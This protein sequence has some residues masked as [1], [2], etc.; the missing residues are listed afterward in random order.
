MRTA[1][2]WAG[3]MLG[4]IAGAWAGWYGAIAGLVLGFMVDEARSESKTR[5]S[6]RAFLAEPDRVEPEEPLPG[7]ASAAALALSPAFFGLGDNASAARQGFESLCFTML[8]LERSE[9]RWLR[10]VLDLT[11]RSPATALAQH[12]R[13]LA[14]NGCPA[15]R[16]LL[17]DFCYSRFALSARRHEGA[18][19]MRLRSALADCG[20]DARSIEESRSSAFPAARDPWRIL[21]LRPGSPAAEIRRAF[22]RLSRQ[23]HPDAAAGSLGAEEAGSRFMA[24]RSAYEELMGRPGRTDGGA[25]S[26]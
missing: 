26:P 7:I 6:I 25:G 13:R 8:A 5:R 15:S 3:R 19:E 1:G 24:L 12:A 16:R 2:P 4:L 10:T 17:A 9:L 11:E 22:R 20:L 23:Y 18:A 14:L 21:G